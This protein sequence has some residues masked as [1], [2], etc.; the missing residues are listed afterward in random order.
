VR[1]LHR[2]HK[3]P[4]VFMAPAPAPEDTGEILAEILDDLGAHHRR[5]FSRD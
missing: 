4:E 1:L 5:P 2:R 3:T